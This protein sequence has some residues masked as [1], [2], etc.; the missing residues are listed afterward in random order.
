MVDVRDRDA[1]A[2]SIPEMRRRV[3]RAGS[4]GA[5]RPLS[6]LSRDQVLALSPD[7]VNG[8]ES[9]AVDPRRSTGPRLRKQSACRVGGALQRFI[10]HHAY[11]YPA[12]PAA[13]RPANTQSTRAQPRPCAAGPGGIDMT[14]PRSFRTEGLEERAGNRNPRGPHADLPASRGD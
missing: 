1:T 11:V 2:A 6:A 7:R 14:R 4:A 8:A 9:R 10:L 3:E 5:P 13:K 12:V